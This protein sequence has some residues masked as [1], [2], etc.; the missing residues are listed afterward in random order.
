MRKR[1]DSKMNG[2]EEWKQGKKKDKKLEIKHLKYN[3]LTSS[4]IL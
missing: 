3:S 2:S 4:L 1:V